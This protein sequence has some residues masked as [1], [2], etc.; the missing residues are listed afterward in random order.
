MQRSAWRSE[1]QHATH[2]ANATSHKDMFTKRKRN[3]CSKLSHSRAL[4]LGATPLRT[5]PPGATP[6]GATLLD[7]TQ[8]QMQLHVMISAMMIEASFAAT[9]VAH[10]IALPFPSNQLAWPK[11]LQRQQPYS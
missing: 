4:P 6:L 3:I 8:P 7:S 5:T 10:A 11:Q 9:I 2:E 1:V